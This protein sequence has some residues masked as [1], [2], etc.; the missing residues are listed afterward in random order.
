MGARPFNLQCHII[1]RDYR[2]LQQATE[3]IANVLLDG[4]GRPKQMKLVFDVNPD[5][6]YLVRYSGSLGINRLFGYGQF[7]LPLIVIGNPFGHS[8]DS[9][10]AI[11]W[12]SSV[13]WGSSIRWGDTW[14]Y[15]VKGNGSVE[16]NNWGTMILKP[17]IELSGS[18]GNISIT[19]GDK[20]LAYNAPLV[21]ETLIINN[22]RM[23]VKK[24]AEN[25]L[26]HM[27]GDF[28]ELQP[29]I[30]EIS[31]TGTNLNIDVSFKFETLYF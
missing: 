2:T 20:T 28:T 26:K 4:Y 21:S 5:R 10:D 25:V 23:T 18:M 30:N 17:T 11:T 24:G 29:G 15:R 12:G 14:A 13:T 19:C 6:Y 27:T 1:S 22:D 3:H 9:S 16:V 7:T 8:L 31:I